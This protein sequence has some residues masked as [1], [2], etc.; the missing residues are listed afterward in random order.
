[1]AKYGFI[2][3][4]NMAQAMI[5]GL[6]AQGVV[7]SD[8]A[9]ASPTTAA[10]LAQA[11]GVQALSA[12]QVIQASD[13]TVLAFLPNQLADVTANLVFEDQL[14]VSVLAGVS[15]DQ[16]VTA[17]GSHQVVRTLPNVNVAINQ[18]VT[19]FATTTLTVANQ[20]IFH[21]FSTQLGTAIAVPE[22]QFAAFSAIAGSG[23]AYVFKFIDALAK[24][25]VANG[26]ADD[27]ATTI[28]TQTVLGS[29]QMLAASGQS[30]QVMQDTVASPGGSTRAGL[31][32][33]DQQEFDAVVA[34]A[35]RAT[36]EHKH[37]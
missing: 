25:G 5:K 37:A 6:L 11:W 10:K 27:L 16:L 20:A 33:F 9:V 14:V 32:D 21:D 19:A 7:P 36:V 29:A 15:V 34:H 18:G 28:A 31:D 17:T 13:L 4:G 24:A 2:G 23:P 8:I 1:M 12:Q 26:L 22:A 3:T 30:A 35:I